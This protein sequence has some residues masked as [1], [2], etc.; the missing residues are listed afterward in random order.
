[1][2]YAVRDSCRHS[3]STLFFLKCIEFMWSKIR[4]RPGLKHRKNKRHLENLTLRSICFHG[5]VWFLIFSPC[6]VWVTMDVCLSGQI[7]LLLN[8]WTNKKMLLYGVIKNC[9][10]IKLGKKIG[11]EVPKRAKIRFSVAPCSERSMSKPGEKSLI[12]LHYH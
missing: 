5:L 7:Y 1:M 4:R 2:L 12:I 11:Q 8:R 9:P 6:M 10:R 3:I